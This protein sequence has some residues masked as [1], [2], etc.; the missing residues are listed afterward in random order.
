M[1]KR[2][3]LLTEPIHAALVKLALPLMG[4]SMI[5][6]TYNLTDTFW[7]GKLGAGPVASVGTGGQL[8]WLGISLHTIAQLGGQVFVA[9]KIG[10][11]DLKTAGQ[12]ATAAITLSATLSII[13]G[14]L[15]GFATAPIVGF[16][17]LNDPE[18]VANAILYLRITGGFIFFSLLA[19][20]LTAIITTTG[21]SKTPFIATTIGLVFN[22]V[23]D[24]ILIFGWFGAPALGVLGA[25][26]ATVIAQ[27]IVF[28]LLLWQ[29]L[30]RQHLFAHVSLGN[31]PKVH[32]FVDIIKLGFPTTIQSSVYP[33]VSMVLSRLVAGFGDE[34]VAVQ[35]IGS[36]IESISWMTSDGFAIAVNSFMA[37][38]YG[39][40]NLKRTKHGYYQAFLIMSG[41]GLCNTLLLILCDTQI[42]SLF[43]DEPAVVQMG[44]VYLMVLGVS[45]LFMCIE[46][47]SSSAMNALGRTMLPAVTSISFTALRIPLAMA[48]S[49]SALG[50]AGIW[51]GITISTICKGIL[52]A[53]MILTVLHHLTQA[54]QNIGDCK[55]QSQ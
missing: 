14:L 22:I 10:A 9:Q 13:L 43:I 47:I 20:L 34:A 1:A 33:A 31:F 25:A 2:V 17:Q 39:A 26:I 27:A 38:N 51:W 16:F 30:Q 49:A 28:G 48:L 15:F 44:G 3:N 24:P 45:Q 11:G 7:I 29:V 18:V 42:F 4:M 5:Q 32:I 36:Q 23:L 35:R 46:I 21:D 54:P 55:K 40:R 12:Y 37:Q 6:M 8:L 41:I 50:L 52:M 19:K 53:I